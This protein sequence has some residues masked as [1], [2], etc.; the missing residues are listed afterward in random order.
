MKTI[1]LLVVVFCIANCG[2]TTSLE[3]Q[4]NWIVG[5]IFHTSSGPVQGHAAS[6][7][8]R[9]SEYLRI[10]YALPPIGDLRWAAPQNFS[11]NTTINGT[12]FVNIH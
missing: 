8:T 1:S 2:A 12:S 6:N 10:P 9:V 4:S 3:R 7:A 11:G 5:Q